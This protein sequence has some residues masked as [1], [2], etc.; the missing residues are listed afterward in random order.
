MTAVRELQEKLGFPLD[1]TLA[2]VIEYNVPG[3]C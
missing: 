3:T 2:K 1:V